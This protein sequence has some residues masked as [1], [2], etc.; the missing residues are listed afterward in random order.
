MDIRIRNAITND[1]GSVIKIISQ[2]QDMHVEWRPDI[3]KYNDNLITKEEFEKL[4][5]NN[6]FFVA[7]NENKKIVG[8]LEIILRHI[9]SPAHV[10]RDVIFIDTMAVDEKYRGLGVGH[11]M[12]E[13]LKMMKIEKN[14]DGIELQV[15]ARN[16]AAY[17]M[18][19][20]YGFTEKSII[21]ELLAR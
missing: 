4:V 1:Y 10:T 18:Y 7:E 13:F 3:Y 21:M 19:K 8:V 20:K 11:K 16:R 15:N 17:E 14:I 6:T 2:V 5:E 9:E 12:F